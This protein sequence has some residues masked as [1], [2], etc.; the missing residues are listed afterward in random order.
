MDYQPARVFGY[1]SVSDVCRMCGS[2]SGLRRRIQ[3][4]SVPGPTHQ[5]GRKKYYTHDEAQA[6]VK[7]YSQRSMWGK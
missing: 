1:L 2:H 5:Y 3:R 7:A 6:V 4:G